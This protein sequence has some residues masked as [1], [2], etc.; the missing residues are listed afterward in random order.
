MGDISRNELGVNSSPV[1]GE[2]YFKKG[3]YNTT[4]NPDGEY[5][6]RRQALSNIKQDTTYF[7]NTLTSDS[8]SYRDIN[9]DII[10]YLVLERD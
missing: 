7:D 5:W 4:Y 10:T 9:Y 6:D 2:K 3:N 1:E 8:T